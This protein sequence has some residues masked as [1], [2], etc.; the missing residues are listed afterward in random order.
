MAPQFFSVCLVFFFFCLLQM[1][2][3]NTL[4]LAEDNSCYVIS[5][6]KTVNDAYVNVT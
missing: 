5:S 6:F 4:R 1:I 3:G 2:F